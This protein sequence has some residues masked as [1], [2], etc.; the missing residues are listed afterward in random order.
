MSRY[1]GI[2]GVK[3]GYTTKAGNTLI[4]AARRN[5][6]TLLVTVLNPQS[7][8]Y[9]A[10]YKEAAS[11][12]D[13][14]FG[15]AGTAQPVGTLHAVRA[16]YDGGGQFRPVA[17]HV[18]GARSTRR[19]PPALHPRPGGGRRRR[20]GSR[21]GCAARP[22]AAGTRT[23]RAEGRR[24]VGTWAGGPCGPWCVRERRPAPLVPAE[25]G[26]GVIRRRSAR[27]RPGS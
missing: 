13:W 7:N 17:A 1:P 3:N 6:R 15:T 25:P 4:A 20:R 11:L 14:G 26:P 10:V 16:A 2:I 24:G 9:N 8:E 12:L 22:V 27:P 23:R 21:A 19:L 18:T 5:G